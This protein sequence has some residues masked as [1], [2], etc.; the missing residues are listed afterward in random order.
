MKIGRMYRAISLDFTGKFDFQITEGTHSGA[1]GHQTIPCYWITFYDLDGNQVGRR[2]GINKMDVERDGFLLSFAA[3]P[4]VNRQFYQTD[5]N[6]LRL[7][8]ALLVLLREKK[9]EHDNN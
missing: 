9:A 3:L 8:A 5:E 1:G 6:A 7:Q 4:A 2:E